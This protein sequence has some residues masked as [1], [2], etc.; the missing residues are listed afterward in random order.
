[1]NIHTNIYNH[2]QTCLY[3]LINNVTFMDPIRTVGFAKV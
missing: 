3:I 2:L 1:M